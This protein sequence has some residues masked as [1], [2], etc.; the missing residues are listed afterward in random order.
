MH[1]CSRP[2]LTNSLMINKVEGDARVNKDNI[3]HEQNSH[4]SNNIEKSFESTHS[5]LGKP[6]L[7]GYDDVFSI[8]TD[9]ALG[10]RFGRRDIKIKLVSFI[11]LV[12]V[13]VGEIIIATTFENSSNKLF[14]SKDSQSSND[15]TSK[16]AS[17]RTA[18]MLS[19]M[20]AYL[21]Y[22]IITVHVVALLSMLLE[23]WLHQNK[24]VA[25]LY[26]DE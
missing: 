11:F 17:R 7:H 5:F 16:G 19:C 4:G 6:S 14:N 15:V 18:A 9:K 10:L 8:R 20:L 24:T 23:K 25:D 2:S 21:L 3:Q 12:L 13:Q 22:F 1:L 26:D